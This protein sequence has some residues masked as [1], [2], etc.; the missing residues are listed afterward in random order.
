MHIGVFKKKKMKGERPHHWPATLNRFW[1]VVMVMLS[2]LLLY[3][4]LPCLNAYRHDGREEREREKVSHNLKLCTSFLFFYCVYIHSQWQRCGNLIAGREWDGQWDGRREGPTKW[5]CPVCST[6][7]MRK[8][9]KKR[10]QRTVYNLGYIGNHSE[11]T[12]W[13]PTFIRSMLFK[14]IAFG[15]DQ[16]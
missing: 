5:V 7:G 13:Y 2:T 6:T 4:L 10:E 8:A 11:I 16:F 1:I 3:Y 9:K 14:S 12:W 15:R